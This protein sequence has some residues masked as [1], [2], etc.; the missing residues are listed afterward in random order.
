[1]LPFQG[2]NN[3]TVLARRE[4]K[5]SGGSSRIGLVILYFFLISHY[6]VRR[7]LLRISSP[8]GRV[9]IAIYSPTNSP[10]RNNL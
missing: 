8:S 1:M 9:S 10:V 3:R 7:V 6:S 4:T 5:S 2:R